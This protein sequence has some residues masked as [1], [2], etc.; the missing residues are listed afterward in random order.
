VQAALDGKQDKLVYM[1][2]TDYDA[3]TSKDAAAV[4]LV[5]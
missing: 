4:Y 2:Q 5:G 1:T 3:L